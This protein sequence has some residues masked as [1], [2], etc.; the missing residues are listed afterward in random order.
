[1]AAIHTVLARR[2]GHVTADVPKPGT[3]AYVVKVCKSCVAYCLTHNEAVG[4]ISPKRFLISSGG[5]TGLFASN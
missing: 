1:M 3:P 2:R 4:S 5:I